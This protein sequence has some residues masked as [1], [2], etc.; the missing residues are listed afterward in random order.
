VEDRQTGRKPEKEIELDS[1][2]YPTGKNGIVWGTFDVRQA[3]IIRNA[4]LTQRIVCELRE[5]KLNNTTLHLLH[6]ADEREM[7]EAMEFIWK[8]AGGL[9]LKP[10]WSYP[11]G[12]VNKSFKGWLNGL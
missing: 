8:D 5:R 7:H 4:L 9:R 3:E 11:E 6:V 12:I 1:T 2:G 10:D